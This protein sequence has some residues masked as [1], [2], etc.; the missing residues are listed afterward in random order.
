MCNILHFLLHDP[1]LEESIS[2]EPTFLETYTAEELEA[3]K[4][5]RI[6]PTHMRPDLLPADVFKRGRKIILTFRNP[7]D[8]AVSLYHHARNDRVIGNELRVSWDCF[9]D[10]WMKGLCE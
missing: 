8:T 10:C 6:L 7:K 4:S 1:S 5:P 3:V 2:I 9:I